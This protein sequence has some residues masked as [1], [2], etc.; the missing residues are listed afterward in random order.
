MIDKV[1]AKRVLGLS[2]SGTLSIQDKVNVL[3]RQGV[4][5]FS[6]SNRQ[7]TPEKAIEAAKKA[8]EQSWS[9]SY[10]DTAGLL[11]LRQAIAE[12][13]LVRNGLKVDPEAE[14][15][16]TVGAKE[17]IFIAIQTIVNPDD[18]VLLPDP[19]WVS[20]EPCVCLAGGKI[21]RFPLLEENQFRIDLDDL[22]KR[23]TPRT[24][25]IIINTPHNPTG[26]VIDRDT[27]EGIAKLAQK[28]NLLV[29]SDECYQYYVYDENKHLSI[30][31]FPGMKE[32]TITVSTASKIFNMFGWRVGWAM[33]PKEIIKQMLNVHQHSV[34]CCTSF[35]Q[36]G[37][38]AAV[39]LSQESIDLIL[40]QYREAREV[41]V[42]EL[43]RV[44]GF[45]CRKPA[46]AYFA[47]PNIKGLSLSST[48]VAQWLIEKGAVQSVPGIAF[49]PLGEGHIRFIFACTPDDVREG[50]ERIR[51]AVGT[52][53][54]RR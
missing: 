34:A 17:A 42:E 21:V 27:L 49:G 14:V 4:N 30:G 29:L 28:Y 19:A 3:K 12:N 15:I 40:R 45:S 23:V 50:I 36:A 11:E 46:G 32:L 52:L 9:S 54:P 35:A 25:M 39:K 5:I 44:P 8:L 13:A 7:K 43:N 2:P 26:L 53:K 20:Y 48:E 1:F 51:K 18:E 10:T 31:S 47:F 16:V 22:A 33:G 6:F 41:M 37:A 24:K 38:I